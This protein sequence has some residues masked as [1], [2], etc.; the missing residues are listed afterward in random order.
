MAAITID[1]Y[2]RALRQ[3]EVINDN[4]KIQL[5][6]AR[7]L[8]ETNATKY[9][10]TETGKLEFETKL[11]SRITSLAEKYD[12]RKQLEGDLKT[13]T[14]EA[15]KAL[16]TKSKELDSNIK[17]AID[18]ISKSDISDI[19]KSFIEKYYQFLSGLSLDQIVAVFNL[20]IDFTLGYSLFTLASLFMGEHVIDYFKL[21]NKYPKLASLIR[22][23]ITLNKHLKMFNL[24]F[25]IIFLLAGIVGNLYM[26]LLK[27]FV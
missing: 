4:T 7:K 11:K 21:A 24:S 18:D 12:A 26:F 27:Y 3:D 17:K 1:G 15:K 2:S 16:E 14:G 25:F 9:F 23:K 20:L 19:F 5:D 13:A 6:E 8:A 10:N 22:L